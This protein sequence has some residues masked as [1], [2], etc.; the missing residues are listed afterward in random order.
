MEKPSLQDVSALLHAWRGGDKAALDRLMPLVYSELRRLAH[1]YMAR[2]RAGHSLQTTALINEAYIRLVDLNRIEW[3]DRAHFF[4]IA[5]SFMRRILVDRA[6]SRAYLKRGGEV[7]KVSLDEALVVPAESGLDMVQLDD[8]LNALADFD[9]RKAR[10][11]ELRFFGGLTETETAEVLEVSRE[12][13][14]R[15]WRVAKM[16]LLC[17][18][19]D[20]ANKHE[21]RTLAGDQKDL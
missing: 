21:T 2:E 6:R 20:G 4:A 8:A 16:W 15:D 17:E 13:V 14:K 3:R 5:A 12:T 11:V 19:T 10:V 1:R 18:M 9:A 7:K